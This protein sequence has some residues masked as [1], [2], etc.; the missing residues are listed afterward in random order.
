MKTYI[1]AKGDIVWLTFN[2]QSDHEQ[3]GRRPAIIV[4][5]TLFNEKTGLVVAC[6]VTS[7]VRNYPL[8]VAVQNCEKNI[9]IIIFIIIMINI[10]NR[11]NV[12]AIQDLHYS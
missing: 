3:M 10:G 4:S 2:P 6:P 8:H 5:N 7:T 9:I 1:P 11:M 12:S